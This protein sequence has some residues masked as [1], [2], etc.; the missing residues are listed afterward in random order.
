VILRKFVVEL[1]PCFRL[2]LVTTVEN[3]MVSSALYGLRMKGLQE[4]NAEDFEG[5]VGYGA[6]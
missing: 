6:F 5:F 3:I 2:C 1:K 4:E